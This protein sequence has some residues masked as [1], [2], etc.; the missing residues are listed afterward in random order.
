MKI[1]RGKM[2]EQRLK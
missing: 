2:R 1:A